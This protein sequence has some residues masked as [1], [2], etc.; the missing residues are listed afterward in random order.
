MHLVWNT[1]NLVVPRDKGQPDQHISCSLSFWILGKGY[2]CFCIELNGFHT[3]LT[4][5]SVFFLLRRDVEPISTFH[6][7]VVSAI[8]T[9]VTSDFALTPLVSNDLEEIGVVGPGLSTS[10]QQTV[11]P[12]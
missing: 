10:Q 5:P 2:I 7:P 3:R 8:N 1:V 12:K 4:I 11:R 9:L 6:L